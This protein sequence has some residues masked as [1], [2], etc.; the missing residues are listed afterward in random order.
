MSKPLV[1]IVVPVFNGAPYLA[2]CLQSVLD[3]THQNWKVIVVNNCSSDETGA[4]ADDYCRRDVRIRAVH[5]TEFVGQCENYNRAVAQVSKEADYIKVLEADN[6][7]TPDCLERKIA[8]A[9][10]DPQAGIVGSY[11]LRGKYVDGSGLDPAQ[12]VIPGA[13]VCR[14]LFRNRVYL[15]GTPSTLLF[16]GKALLEEPV[17]FRPGL[18]YDDLEL[19]VR[20]LR[21]WKFGY[22]H[23]VLTFIR[24]DNHGLYSEIRQN[25]DEAAYRYF[26]IKEYGQ[27]WF[28]R[29]ELVEVRRKCEREYFDCLGAAMLAGRNETYWTLH[30]QLWERDG[31]EIRRR[32]FLVPIARAVLERALNPLAS[33]RTWHRRRRLLS[34][35]KHGV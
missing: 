27:E 23:Q 31:R 22:V 9:E 35:H 6:W 20:V 19:C 24:D 15:V 2:E 10:K 29:E 28:D 1:E 11:W 5:C 12:K 18:Y 25:D 21:K 7:I 32:N 16:R 4:I 3:Q 17:W 33:A 34:A 26:L 13:E 8:V 14:L 30:R